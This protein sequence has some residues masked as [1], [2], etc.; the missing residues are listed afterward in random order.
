[1]RI[2]IKWEIG[3]KVLVCGDR[4][5]TNVD[6][7]RRWLI[8]LKDSG[9]TIVIEGE[10]HGADTIARNLAE[11]MNLEVLRFPA[12]WKK[13]HKAAGSIRNTQMLDEGKPDLIFAFHN[14]IENSKGTKNMISQ[15]KKRDINIILIAEN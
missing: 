3:I 7:I 11:E 13:F 1:M 14:N 15:A 2:K 9:Y 8:R 5:W 6:L 10:A 12:N 4:N